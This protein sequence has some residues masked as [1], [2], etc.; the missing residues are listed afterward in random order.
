MCNSLGSIVDVVPNATR[1]AGTAGQETPWESE[2][3][4]NCGTVALNPEILAAVADPPALEPRE[5][6]SILLVLHTVCLRGAADLGPL[7]Q[8]VGLT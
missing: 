1:A 3:N 4:R 2:G 6:A 5:C 8:T 7:T